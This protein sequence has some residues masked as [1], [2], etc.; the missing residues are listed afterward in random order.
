M[1]SLAELRSCT[2]LSQSEFAKSYNI[3]IRNI[4]RWEK[5]DRNP[6]DYVLSLLQA[7]IEKEAVIQK[8]LDSE[9]FKALDDEYN[10]TYIYT[11]FDSEEGGEF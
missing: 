1:M 10:A 9:D 11:D 3:P 5:G 7:L 4:Q 8:L 6:P 2:G